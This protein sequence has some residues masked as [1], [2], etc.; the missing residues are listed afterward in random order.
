M[1]I[2]CVIVDM[3]SGT[4]VVGMPFGLTSKGP[5]CKPLRVSIQMGVSGYKNKRR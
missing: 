2:V 1:I 3:L 4:P 5:R